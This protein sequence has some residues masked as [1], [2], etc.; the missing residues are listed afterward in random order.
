MHNI[1]ISKGEE[2][3]EELHHG[4]KELPTLKCKNKPVKIANEL[5]YSLKDFLLRNNKRLWQLHF[6]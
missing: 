1:N 4:F 2:T 5:K 6:N 3:N